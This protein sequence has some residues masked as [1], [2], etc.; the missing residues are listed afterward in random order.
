MR[1]LFI[2]FFSILLSCGVEEDTIVGNDSSQDSK[3]RSFYM[4]FTPWLYEASS[5]AENEVYTFINNNGD[6]IAHHFQQG[7]PFDDASTFPNYSNYE[8]NIQNEI[9]N[10]INKTNI[11]CS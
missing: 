11:S 4:G 3:T 1:I 2:T 8:N 6:L 9:N 10:R 7:I 5:S